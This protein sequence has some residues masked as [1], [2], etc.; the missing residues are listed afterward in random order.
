MTGQVLITGADGYIGRRIAAR[1]LADSDDR[2]LL[3]VHAAGG[4]DLAARAAALGREFAR[5]GLACERVQVLPADLVAA[6]PFAAINPAGITG[7]VHAAARTAFNIDREVARQVN[8]GGTQRLGAFARRCPKL[9]RLLV[10][11][12]LFSAGRQTGK[13]AEAPHDGRRSFVNHYEWSKYEAE[14]HVLGTCA[15]LPLSVARVATV[16]ADDET[17]SVTQYNV[18]HNTLKLFFY[19]L[20]SLMPGDPGTRLYL[21]T[22]SFLSRAA[23]RLLRPE[24]PA[25]VYHLTPSPSETVTLGEAVDIAFTAFEADAGF[26]RRR[27][28]RPDFGDLESF[29]YLAEATRS[30]S[31]SPLA[32]AVGSVTPF[33]EQM[34]LPKEFDNDRLRRA[35]PE[36]PPTEPAR[37][38]AAV[39]ERLIVTR[40][41]RMDSQAQ[42][43]KR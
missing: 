24:V 22:A 42:E 36:Y 19:G 7:V 8:L 16:V 12:T 15:D 6:D 1:L 31:G 30:L 3:T 33:A 18:F 43:E 29:R 25:G 13:V 9:E 38:V 4:A 41:G 40:W 21:T 5:A 17:G 26:R 23:A 34:F 37:L 35:W 20:L 14:R 28:L 32:Q 10:M 27:L 39:S 2:L 11:S